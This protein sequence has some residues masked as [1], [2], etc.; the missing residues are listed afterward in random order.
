MY[1]RFLVIFAKLSHIIYGGD[2]LITE[3][4]TLRER[5]VINICDGRNLGYVCDFQID[6]DCGKICAIFVSD[7]IFGF[8]GS[9]SSLK[10]P[11]DKI[12]CIG[13]DTILVDIGKRGEECDCRCDNDRKK[14]KRKKYGWLSLG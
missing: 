4:S 5:E 9:K 14:D 13:A 3:S 6:T 11:W 12:S 7:N 1:A 10:I 8:G 2:L